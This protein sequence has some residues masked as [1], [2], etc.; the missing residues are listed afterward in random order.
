[1]GVISHFFCTFV[2]RFMRPK[3]VRIVSRIYCK[4]L[5]YRKIEI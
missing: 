2:L 4:K 3:R 1:M 5:Y